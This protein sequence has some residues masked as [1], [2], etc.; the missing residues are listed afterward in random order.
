MHSRSFRSALSVAAAVAA[1]ALPARAEAPYA[2][3]R[4]QI[5]FADGWQPAQSL[6]PGDSSLSLMYGFSMMGYCYLAA[7]PAGQSDA[8]L[9]A[10]RKQYAGT[11]SLL[12]V[13]DGNATLGGKSFA[14]VEY[15]SA[16]T[17]Y[18]DVR[19]RLYTTSAGD[20]A[21]ASLLIYDVNSGGILVPEVEAALGTLSFGATPVRARLAPPLRVRTP[22]GRDALGRSRPAAPTARFRLPPES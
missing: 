19:L 14:I 3:N 17:A 1:L 22:F 12:K 5:T 20:L 4:F 18:G 9:E 15:K 2:T 8:G 11:D 10:Y 7:V 16:D 13:A 21:F 6:A